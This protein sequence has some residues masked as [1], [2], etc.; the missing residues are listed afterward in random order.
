MIYEIDY[1]NKIFPRNIEELN[2]A[3]ENKNN[4]FNMNSIE[5]LKDYFNKLKK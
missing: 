3:Y 1:N 4:N 2:T 5:S